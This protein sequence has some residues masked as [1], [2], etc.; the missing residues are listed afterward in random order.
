M[1]K[2]EKKGI[3]EKLMFEKKDDEQYTETLRYIN[4]VRGTK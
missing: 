1:L 3:K 4:L 2:Y